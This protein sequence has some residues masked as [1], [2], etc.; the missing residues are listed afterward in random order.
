MLT[1]SYKKSLKTTA[2]ERKFKTKC[3]SYKFHA[4]QKAMFESW[5]EL[6]NEGILYFTT[7]TLIEGLIALS[8]YPLRRIIFHA[9]YF[10][11]T[12]NVKT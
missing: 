2:L 5:F 7:L 8:V 9:P 6:L 10:R 4:R 1:L 11:F 12:F 3:L